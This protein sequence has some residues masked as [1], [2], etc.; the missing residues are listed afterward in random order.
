MIF[1]LD[2][3]AVV[4]LYRDEE[5]SHAMRSLFKDPV[6]KGS[7]FIS[8]L[9]ALEVLVRLAKLGRMGDR[10]ERRDHRRLAA[11]YARHRARY[12]NVVGTEPDVLE[13]AESLAIE[14]DD[15][16]AG[17]LDL[18]HAASARQLQ[19]TIPEQPLVFVVADR[20]LRSLAERIGFQS[21][22]PESGESAPF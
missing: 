19:R 6:N 21:L 7:L 10:K 12:L 3:S 22:D 17:T 4:K 18:L 16:G 5:G 11:M 1:F 9:G 14:Y 13:G 20:K 8:D 15:A 2:A